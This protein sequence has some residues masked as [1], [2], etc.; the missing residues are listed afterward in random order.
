MKINFVQNHPFQKLL[1]ED[2]TDYSDRDKGIIR[3]VQAMEAMSDLEFHVLDYKNRRILYASK[4]AFSYSRK[5]PLDFDWYD[6][7]ILPEDIEMGA[8][9]NTKAFDFFCS[10]PKQR[11]MNGYFTY[12]YRI[13]DKNNQIHLINHRIA[14][15]DMT[16]EGFIRLCLCIFTFSTA[17]KPGNF[18]I[19]MNDTKQVYE[20]FPATESLVEVKTQKISAKALKLLQ[21][22][23]SGKT[24]LQIAQTLNISV[25]TVKYHKKKIF[26]QI[27][28]KNTSEA[29]HWLNTQ[30]HF[31][32]KNG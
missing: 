2:K 13:R 22:V 28:A 12:D 19:K 11:R 29:I 10:L 27:N 5:Q 23:A 26:S 8:K 25:D 17:D 1:D 16:E 7:V 31:A 30:K 6:A 18:Y 14:V 20:Y 3:A 21:L 15:L 24:E 4:K 9:V 32:H